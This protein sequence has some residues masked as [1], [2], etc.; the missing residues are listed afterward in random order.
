M[1]K[2]VCDNCWMTSSAPAK[3]ALHYSQ[4]KLTCDRNYIDHTKIMKGRKRPVLD[5]LR[6]QKC[7]LTKGRE[8]TQFY[9][10]L[11]EYSLPDLS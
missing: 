9:G 5:A 3:S 1:G 4:Q 8:G 10:I 2:A 7:E 11:R 6:I